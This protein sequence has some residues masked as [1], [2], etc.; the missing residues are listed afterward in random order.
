[1]LTDTRKSPNAKVYPVDGLDVEWTKGLWKERFDTCAATTVPQLQHMFE[2]KDISH[3]VENFKICAGES[4]GEF[5]GTVFGDGDFYKWMESAVYTAAKTKNRE[6]LDQ[7]EEY[8][9][10]IGKAQQ[11]DGYISTKQ[12]IGEMRQNGITR[13]GDIND[14]EVYNFGH[15]F[16]AAC[17]HKRI[18]G[19]DSFMEIA[20]RTADYLEH[21]YAEAMASG[22]VQT[23]VCPSHYMGL[24]EMYRTTKESRYLCLAKQAVKLRDSVKDGMDDN[25]DR[26][27][28]REHD[29]IIGHAVRANYLYAGVADLCLE[30]T[31]EDYQRVLHQVWRSLADKK[32]YITG[33]CGALYNG[34]SPYGNFFVDQKI[35]QAYG[36]EYQLPN[37]TAYN[38]TCASLGGVFWAYR[39]FQM[40]PEAEYFDMIERMMLNTNLA[41]LS[42]DGKRFFYENMLRR[43]KKLDYE[44][45]WPLSRSEYILSYCCPPNLA[46]TVAQSSEYAYTVSK[47]TVWLGMYGAN[48]ARIRLEN[49]ADFCLVQ[50]TEYPFDGRIRFTCESVRARQGFF[51]NLRIPG[52]AAGGSISVN[53][54]ERKLT[55]AQAGTY[56]TVEV[57]DSEKTEV[58]LLLDMNV[59]Y[60]TAH[61]MVEEAC[62]QAAVERGPLVYCCEGADTEAE[63][64]DDLYLDPDA[65][66]GT[67][68]IE[69]EGRRISALETEFYRMDREGYDRNALYQPLVFRGMQKEKVRLI[70]YYAWDNREF[71]EM[72]IWFPVAYTKEKQEKTAEELLSE[73]R[74]GFRHKIVVLDDDPTGVQTVHGISV[75]TDW[76][77]D[78][79]RSGFDEENDMFFIL[80]NSRSF[81]AEETERVHRE[82]AKR[83]CRIA[84]ETGKAFQLI[85]RGDSTLRGHYPLETQTLRQELE[86]CTGIPVDGEILCPFF[87]EG[88]RITMGNVHYVREGSMLV[89]AGMTEFAKDQTFGYKASDLTEYVEEKTA[90]TYRKESCICITLEELQNRETE[91]ILEKLLSAERFDKIIVNAVSYED[92][93][94]FCAVYMD[95]VKAGKRYLARTAAAFPKVLGGIA[96]QP[97]LGR[98]ELRQEEKNG[99]IV[100]IGSHVNKTTRQLECLMKGKAELESMEFDVSMQSVP[101]GLQKEAERVTEWADSVIGSGKTAVI[102]TSRRVLAPDTED[103]NQIL[104]ASVRISDAVTS[105]IGRLQVKPSFI[106]AKGGITSSDVGTKAL[107]VKKARV[108]G[109]VQKG[110]PVWMTGAESKFPGMPYIIFPGNVGDD[111]TLRNIVE[112]LV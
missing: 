55:K 49:G 18:T 56:Q 70:P 81:S 8:I 89:P 25:Q 110:I 53:G 87:P 45:I 73:S 31:D 57:T 58:L 48:R 66:F 26:I 9:R 7:I 14:F 90:G 109:Q 102:Y 108:M 103:K 111:N 106:I 46:R 44:L 94:T 12:I 35:H 20:V 72:R 79:I 15:L 5:D 16:T 92:L 54:E 88:G 19:K 91:R 65:E 32:I 24:V 62:G 34:A 82:I 112:E 107:H 47:D 38:E 33:G 3:V 41:A 37:I 104:E 86:K 101:G 36:Y 42:L 75:Y 99:G 74:D 22:E 60:T 67:A 2:S 61:H 10:L 28:L 68:Q 96:D 17:L 6:L 69:I 39:M 95:A 71:G 93:K 85:S 40:E 98:K 50:D 51:L 43:A 78:S 77:E 30:E 64:L 100:L 52:W 27:P 1:M 83:V 76:D 13:M 80:T 21:L 84:G 105:V 23:A 4:D 59:R 11:P 29:R 97:L 63:T